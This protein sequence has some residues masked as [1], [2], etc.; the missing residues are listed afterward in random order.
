MGAEGKIVR[1]LALLTALA[2]CMLLAFRPASAQAAESVEAGVPPSMVG[3]E[4]FVSENDGQVAF[5]ERGAKA[6]GYSDSDVQT[7]AGQ[8]EAMNEQIEIGDGYLANDGTVVAQEDKADADVNPLFRAARARGVNKTVYHW[9]GQV[10]HWT[11]SNRANSL[12]SAL[13]RGKA[14]VG[15]VNAVVPIPNLYK[16]ATN[17][18]MTGLAISA[19]AAAKPGWNHHVHEA[20][21]RRFNHDTHV[22]WPSAV[23]NGVL[24]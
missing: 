16:W 14:G 2:C 7:V 19:E 6:A 5:D 12:I 3:M 17:G 23:M 10:D 20:V 24:R 4:R 18:H 1:V 11:D 22:V 8:V 9:W 15:A 13:K 21:S